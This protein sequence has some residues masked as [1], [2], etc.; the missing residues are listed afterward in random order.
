MWTFLVYV[1]PILFVTL[2]LA[3][4]AIVLFRY[5]L[6]TK[7]ESALEQAERIIAEESAALELAEKKTKKENENV[8]SDNQKSL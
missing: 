8:R 1:L 2:H 5:L 4:A 6:S 7:E 3:I